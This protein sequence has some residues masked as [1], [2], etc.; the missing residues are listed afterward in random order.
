MAGRDCGHRLR[1]DYFIQLVAG[2][3]HPHNIVHR[4]RSQLTVPLFGVSNP[5]RWRRPE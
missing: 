5:Y 2:D 1:P 4:D 3:A